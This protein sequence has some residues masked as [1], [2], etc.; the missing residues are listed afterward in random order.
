M[1]SEALLS[2]PLLPYLFIQE[3]TEEGLPDTSLRHFWLPLVTCREYCGSILAAPTTGLNNNIFIYLS[4]YSGYVLCCSAT[5]VS[6]TALTETPSPHLLARYHPPHHCHHLWS[7]EGFLVSLR[8]KNRHNLQ[9]SCRSNIKKYKRP[10]AEQV[11]LYRTKAPMG[12]NV[13]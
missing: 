8:G 7:K 1:F 4:I 10:E 5:L 13:Q 2:L 6:T 11:S 9:I 3:N 12:V